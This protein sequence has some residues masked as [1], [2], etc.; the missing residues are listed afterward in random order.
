M[1]VIIEVGGKQEKIEKGTELAINRVSK[2]EGSDLKIS[3]VLFAKKGN[4]Y[5]IGKPYLKGANVDCQ[6][7][8][9][10]RAKKVIAFKYKKRKSYHRKIGHRQDLTLL[11]GRA[12]HGTKSQ[13]HPH[14][15]NYII[16]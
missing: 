7:L 9:H 14:L 11:K 5:H 16:C 3:H 12:Y 2:K 6:V 10:M 8:S 15:L 13:N 1:Y 4:T